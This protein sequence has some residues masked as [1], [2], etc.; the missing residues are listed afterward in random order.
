MQITSFTLG[1][2]DSFLALAQEEG[3]ISHRRE[4][5]FLLEH[6]PPRMHLVLI[7]R[8]DPLIPIAR[9]RSSCS[10]LLTTSRAKISPLRQRIA[11][12]LRH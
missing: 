11:A 3:W 4:L 10:G 5:A 9:Q 2:I 6:Q 12:A 8:E 7:T 1:D